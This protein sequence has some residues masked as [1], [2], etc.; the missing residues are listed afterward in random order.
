MDFDTWRLEQLA[1]G[2]GPETVVVEA[3]GA[4]CR[5]IANVPGAD[6]RAQ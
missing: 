4:L 5:E 2:R 1:F 6:H 3:S